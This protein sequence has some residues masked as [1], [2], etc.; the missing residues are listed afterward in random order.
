[1]AAVHLLPS[2]PPQYVAIAVHSQD[3]RVQEATQSIFQ[4]AKGTVV[5]AWNATVIGIQV[6]GDKIS[7]IFF[8]VLQ[9]V[10]P[11][12]LAQR[13]EIIYVRICCIW[14]AIK[15]AWKDEK[16]RKELDGLRNEVQVLTGVRQQNEQL[17]QRNQF[18][19]QRIQGLEQL[20]QTLRQEQPAILSQTQAATSARAILD[21]RNR[22][23]E[24][25]KDLANQQR[26][27]ATLLLARSTEA[28]LALDKQ[29]QQIQQELAFRNQFEPDMKESIAEV[30]GAIAQ[31][32]THGEPS[33]FDQKLENCVRQL[34][35]QI[36]T[37]RENLI[38][39]REYLPANCSA[40]IPLTNVIDRVLPKLT[41]QLELV[42]G[43]LLYANSQQ[44]GRQHQKMPVR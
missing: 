9:L 6:A 34:L 37:D 38:K 7:I 16:V 20:I 3:D 2:T 26:D 41:G 33:E 25:Q 30:L 11:T 18:Q 12:V 31:L 40:K 39:A 17:T 8:A 13:A 36:E 32:R 4:E 21:Q 27:A 23:L 15:E 42:P 1:M 19:E 22:D 5:R 14:Q 10:V 44:V 28:N 43:I 24:Q 29:L 35:R